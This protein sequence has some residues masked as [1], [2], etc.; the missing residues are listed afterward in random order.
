MDGGSVDGDDVR[1][2]NVIELACDISIFK[3]KLSLFRYMK[4]TWRDR[5]VMGADL[6]FRIHQL[7]MGFAVFATILSF[8]IIVGDK[9]FLP[10]SHEQLK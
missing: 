2:V 4:E 9:G 8:F 7:M 6:W 1:E 3:I 5:K 10:Y